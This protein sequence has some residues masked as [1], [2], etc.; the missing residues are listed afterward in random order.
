MAFRFTKRPHNCCK[1]CGHGWYPR[2]HNLS[3]RCPRCG[4]SR[5]EFS[6]FLPFNISWRGIGIALLIIVPLSWIALFLQKEWPS[7]SSTPGVQHQTIPVNSSQTSDSGSGRL[8]DRPGLTDKSQEKM[9]SRENPIV[10]RPDPANDKPGENAR[11]TPQ[12]VDL[13]LA[14]RLGPSFLSE[15]VT[16]TIGEAEVKWDLYRLRP[17]GKTTV[18]LSAPGIYP[19]SI[20]SNAAIAGGQNGDIRIPFTI[21]GQGQ[22]EIRAGTTVNYQRDTSRGLKEAKGG[23]RC[24]RM[25]VRCVTGVAYCCSLSRLSS[26]LAGRIDTSTRRLG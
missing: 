10:H 2:G 20:K 7:R 15:Q 23:A 16:I 25:I 24:R 13:T 6:P 8:R 11:S 3:P 9:P 21:S 14:T 5:V 1:T 19:Y 22:I 12:P 18:Q 17:E 26:S 4:G